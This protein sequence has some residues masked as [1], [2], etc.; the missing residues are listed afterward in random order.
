MVPFSQTRARRRF[1]AIQNYFLTFNRRAIPRTN[2]DKLIIIRPVL[3]FMLERCLTLYV[4]LKNL[5]ID[6]GMLKWKGHLSIKVY[7]P[8]KL[9]KY[10][11]KFYFLC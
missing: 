8:Q 10:G 2:T 11:I 7:N 3:S 4:P 9:T 1:K 6:E 5:S